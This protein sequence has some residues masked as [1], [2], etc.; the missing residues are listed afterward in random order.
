MA[1]GC[2]IFDLPTSLEFGED[3]LSLI[4]EYAWQA[5]ES[6]ENIG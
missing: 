1:G 5:N 4:A 6:S 2:M 3:A